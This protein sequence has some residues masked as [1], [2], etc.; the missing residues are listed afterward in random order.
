MRKSVSQTELQWMHLKC[1][2]ETRRLQKTHGQI[3]CIRKMENIPYLIDDAAIGASL[4]DIANWMM[5]GTPNRNIETRYLNYLH[6]VDPDLYNVA[7]RIGS[8]VRSYGFMENLHQQGVLSDSQNQ[9]DINNG[10]G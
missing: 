6:T 3:H 4:E 8:E 1:L 5:S 10:A 2:S 7:M 9:Y